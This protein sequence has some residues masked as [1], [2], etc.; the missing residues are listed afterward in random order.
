CTTHVAMVTEALDAGQE[1]GSDDVWEDAATLHYVT[2]QCAASEVSARELRR[3]MRR[4][5][6]YRHVSGQLFRIMA[7][8]VT[9]ECPH[10][11]RR[12]DLV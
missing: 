8:G 9:R 4:A 7:N 2:H 12:R 6:S 1:L 5:K 10:P 3:I 11:D